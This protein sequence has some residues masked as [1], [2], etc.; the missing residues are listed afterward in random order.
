[1]KINYWIY[2]STHSGTSERFAFSLSEELSEIEIVNDCLNIS[3]LTPQIFNDHNYYI[4]LIS[5]HFDG[6]SCLDG[7]SFYNWLHEEKGKLSLKGKK[8]TLFGLGDK[9]FP[10]FNLCS[11]TY[12]KFFW[13]YDMEEF[14]PYEIGSDHEGNIEMDFLPWKKSLIKFIKGNLSVE[15][16][17]EDKKVFF[18][19]IRVV[20]SDDSPIGTDEN[21]SF[22]FQNYKNSKNG[23]ISK[24]TSCLESDYEGN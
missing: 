21:Y 17:L 7:E 1:M 14:F 3:Q 5:T 24:I 15:K 4:F 2:Y 10:H 23:V 6:Q 11:K 13:Q 12:Y 22:R 18:K 8:F 19:G 9:T 16:H 20:L